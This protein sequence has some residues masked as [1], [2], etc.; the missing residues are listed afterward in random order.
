MA[1]L[2]VLCWALIFIL[3]LRFPPG[4]SI[5]AIRNVCSGHYCDMF[6]KKFRNLTLYCWQ[7][8]VKI[9]CVKKYQPW[10]IS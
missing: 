2:R 6:V 3:R 1:A 8:N 7:K 5:A 10:A 4:S 9:V